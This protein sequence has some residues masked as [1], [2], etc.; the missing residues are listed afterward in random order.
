[1]AKLKWKFD[2]ISKCGVYDKGTDCALIL[3]K[4]DGIVFLR[5]NDEYNISPAQIHHVFMSEPKLFKKGMIGIYADEE[6]LFTTEDGFY[7][8]LEFKRKYKDDFIFM[9]SLFKDNGVDIDLI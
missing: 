3:S 6:N 2:S 7:L 4:E 5:G 8:I 9:Y 1:M